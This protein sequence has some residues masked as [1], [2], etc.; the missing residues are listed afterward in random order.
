MLL[1]N[2]SD[3]NVNLFCSKEIKNRTFNKF[4]YSY[5]AEEKY[6]RMFCR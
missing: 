3:I 4:I 2:M 6:K 5:I 1:D